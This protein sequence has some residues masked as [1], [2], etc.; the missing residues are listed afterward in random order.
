MWIFKNGIFWFAT[1]GPIKPLLYKAGVAR[2]LLKLL[3]LFPIV[4]WV[5]SIQAQR[6]NDNVI[7]IYHRQR[8]Q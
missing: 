3:P 1:S 4:E 8:P 6:E 7:D 2:I 5:N